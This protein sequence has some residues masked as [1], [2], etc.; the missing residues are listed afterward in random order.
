MVYKS[1]ISPP[2]IILSK[3]ALFVHCSL[4]KRHS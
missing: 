4:T 1:A 3:K 2:K